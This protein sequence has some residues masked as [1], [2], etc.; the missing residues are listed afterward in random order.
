MSTPTVRSHELPPRW[1]FI[2]MHAPFI[3]F[4][5]LQVTTGIPNLPGAPGPVALPVVLAA[6][7][8]Q[9]RHSLAAARGTRPRYWLW[10]LLLL[11]LIVYAPLPLVGRTWMTLQW[12][13]IASLAML[14]PARIALSASIAL[15]VMSGTWQATTVG[16]I[17]QQYPW[18]VAYTIMVF[19]VGG[20]ALY[21][22]AVI[23]RL[24]DELNE[25]R[26]VLG[27]VAIERE[28][29]RI[30]RDLHDVLGQS[31]SAVSLK[32]QLAIGLLQR[33]ETRAAAAEIEDAVAVTRSVLHDLRDIP[34]GALPMSLRTEIERA[35]DLLAAAGI[36][37]RFNAAIEHLPARSEELLAWAIREGVTNVL[38]HS[39]ANLCS[40]AIQRDDDTIRMEMRNDG[41]QRA[42]DEAVGHGLSGLAARA[43]ALS[44]SATGSVEGSSFRLVVQLPV[45]AT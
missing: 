30:S 1:V 19:C 9:M 28:R 12:F 14:L 26:A 16:A 5:I 18:G 2:A 7:A 20:W 13:A 36:K 40:I 23:V 4:P 44:G 27:D 41:A 25:A 39:S 38:R 43:A 37:A 34:H 10:S 11:L 33:N 24:I 17:G 3:A 15:C 21:G 32:G 31:L 22:S 45:A 8:I 42:E 35:A 29:L 6:A